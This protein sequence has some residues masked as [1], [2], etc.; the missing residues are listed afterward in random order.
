MPTV[1]TEMPMSINSAK[2]NAEDPAKLSR[3]QLAR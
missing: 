3:K 2:S 1:Q